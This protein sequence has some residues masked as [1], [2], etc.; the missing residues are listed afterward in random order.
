VT[1]DK[2]WRGAPFKLLR[3]GLLQ[4]QGRPPG[5]TR[6]GA[7][8]PCTQGQAQSSR[9]KSPQKGQSSEED[10][11]RA[12]WW[13]LKGLASSVASSNLQHCCHLGT[14]LARIACVTFLKGLIGQ[15]CT[16]REIGSRKLSEGPCDAGNTCNWWNLVMS[17]VPAGKAAHSG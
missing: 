10:G 17:L 15:S 2:S 4:G 7:R 12:A 1:N 13:P 5:S 11:R 3:I 16:A 14:L 8:Q 9:R 6:P